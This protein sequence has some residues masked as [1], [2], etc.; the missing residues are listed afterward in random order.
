MLQVDDSPEQEPDIYRGRF[1]GCFREHHAR[2]LAFTMR[3]ISGR[4]AAEEVVADTFA[5]AWRRRDRIPDSPLPWLYAIANNVLADQYRSTRR[6]RDLGLRLAHEARADASGGDPAES[7]A[8]RE[9]FSAAFA[10]LEEGEREVLRLVAWDGLDVARGGGGARLLA[11]RLPG[12][13]PSGPAQ[14]REATRRRQTDRPGMPGPGAQAGRGGPMT[15]RNRPDALARMRAANP[16]SADELREATGEPELLGAMR[17]AIA[18]GEAPTRPIPAADRVATRR[19]A[20]GRPRRAGIVSRHRVASLGFGLACVAVIAV[21]VV[22]GGGSV[23]TSRRVAALP[24]RLRRSRS[25]K[26]I[27]ASSSLPLAGRSSTPTS[28]PTTAG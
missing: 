2:L 20:G 1:E 22:L 5:V 14:A 9:A 3:R 15:R 10:Q 23:D 13:P 21:L 24:T 25:P 7:L 12:A 18:A 26:P 16:A 11:G 8:L 28:R 4:E 27:H 17:R 19:G 6:R